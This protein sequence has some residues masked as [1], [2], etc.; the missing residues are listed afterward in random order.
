M[1]VVHALQP[2]LR[3]ESISVSRGQ[4]SRNIRARA[5]DSRDLVVSLSN[6]AVTRARCSFVV[7]KK[8]AKL[9]PTVLAHYPPPILSTLIERTLFPA[10]RRRRPVSGLTLILFAFGMDDARA[11]FP[12]RLGNRECAAKIRTAERN[13]DYVIKP[14]TVAAAAA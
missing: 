9:R 5:R 7:P 8:C 2:L 1:N 4:V 3:T 14:L 12:V 6:F 11:I 10:L 13:V